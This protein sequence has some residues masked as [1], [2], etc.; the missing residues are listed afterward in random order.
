M[1]EK[2]RKPIVLDNECEDFVV[3][4]SQDVQDEKEVK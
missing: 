3:G 1:K 4:D 2:V